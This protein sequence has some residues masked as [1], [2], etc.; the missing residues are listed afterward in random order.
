MIIILAI[1]ACLIVTVCLF[2]LL[3]SAYKKTNAFQ[4]QFVDIRKLKS[5]EKI[6]DG[7]VDVVNLGSNAPKF[8]FDYTDVKG[9]KGLN[10]AVGPETF[11]Y[12]FKI[13]KLFT[14]KLHKGSTV[15][16]PISPGNFFLLKFI[17]LSNVVKYYAL[18]SKEDIPDYNKKQYISE[19]LFPLVHP[20]RLKAIIRDAKKDSRM[21]LESNP[22]TE[23]E[24]KADATSWIERCWN[25]EFG[26][27][28]Q[29]MQPLS[30]KNKHSVRENIKNVREIAN[31]CKNKGFRLI[32]AY[33][34]LSKEL[35]S[36]FSTDYVQKYMTDYVNESIDGTEAKFVDYMHDSRF[37][38]KD[39]Y[40]N[41][42]FM[43][44]KG[45]KLFT[46]IFINEQ[47]KV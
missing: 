3:N 8:A 12:D 43:N 10:L 30:E 45:A 16:L 42:F 23:E 25:P 37:E 31:Y 29:N 1:I 40:I 15:I 35:G 4:N 39:Y 2:L 11:E 6:S 38:N 19:Y 27:D 21:E 36:K 17:P 7:S 20:R 14:N 9:I 32:V 46:N 13:L 22:M 34:P 41:S 44:R 24:V 5:Y 28:I 18:L 33:L 26:I 47:V